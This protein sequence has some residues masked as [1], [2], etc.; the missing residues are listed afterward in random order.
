MYTPWGETQSTAAI[1]PGII[2]C[3]TASHG[4]FFVDA[5]RFAAMPPQYQALVYPCM[6]INGG[7]W[8]EEDSAWVAV[9]L[10]F[11][12][13]FESYNRRKLES[14]KHAPMAPCAFPTNRLYYYRDGQYYTQEERDSTINYYTRQLTEMP[15]RAKQIYENWYV[16][17]QSGEETT[18]GPTLHL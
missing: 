8:F 11:P 9:V 18:N 2:S 4:G 12:Y 1:A 13:E 15:E 14:W 3:S 17:R 6:A 5:D 7:A 16:K 10:S